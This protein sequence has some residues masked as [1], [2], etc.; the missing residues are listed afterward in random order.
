MSERKPP[1]LHRRIFHLSD[2][3]NDSFACFGRHIAAILG[4]TTVVSAPVLAFAAYQIVWFHEHGELS[5]EIEM[6]R[7]VEGFVS[8]F[9]LQPLTAAIIVTAL[10]HSLMEKPV[11]LGESALV[12]LR[13][14]P[15]VVLV[16][17]AQGL[18]ILSLAVCVGLLGLV[19]SMAVG[20]GLVVLFILAGVACLIPVMIGFYVSVPAVVIEE[21]TP[22]EAIRRSFRL[23]KGYRGQVF[24][25]I[26][27]L[28]LLAFAMGFLAILMPRFLTDAG[29]SVATAFALN[30]ICQTVLTLAVS[31]L[32]AVTQTVCYYHLRCSREGL[33]VE[34]MVKVFDE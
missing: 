1:S 11:T 26:L 31:G 17:L 28:G 3:L 22:A 15:R 8:Q 20:P 12:G 25:L 30:T 6:A 29:C 9:V 19:V 4:I 24:G 33:D 18:I 21:I 10:F 7:V 27:V 34:A 16:L 32:G 14:L 23:T 13:R 2:V 5:S